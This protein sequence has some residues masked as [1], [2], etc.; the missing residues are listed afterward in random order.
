MKRS[1]F[2]AGSATSTFLD[3]ND[4][5]VLAPGSPSSR[6]CEEDDEE[7]PEEGGEPAWK[8]EASMRDEIAS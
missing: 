4:P 7:G 6:A 8:E 5:L 2:T 1:A 3:L